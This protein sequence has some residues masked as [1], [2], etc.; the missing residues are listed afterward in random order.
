MVTFLLS[1][2]AE[3]NSTDEDGR[4]PFMLASLGG[5]LG[6]VRVLGEAMGGGRVNAE[7]EEGS[8]ALHLA[9]SEGHAE[10]VSFL[11]SMGAVIDTV[12]VDTRTPLMS[13]SV[14]GHV[15]V[16]RVL[17]EVMGKDE[18]EETDGDE[19]TALHLAADQ[20]HEEVV[21]VLL[22]KGAQTSCT[23]VE[24][25][26]PLMDGVSGGHLG[27]VKVFV[28]HRE[29]RGLEEVEDN[30]FTV[31]HLAAESGHVEVL[32]FLLVAGA[33]LTMTD[34]HGRTPRALAEAKGHDKCVAVIDVSNVRF[35]EV[36]I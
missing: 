31:L 13:A 32:R 3:A 9:A 19:I 21:R 36:S 27:V 6:V 8:T 12:D 7:D 24:G 35:F 15:G 29:G 20:G 34:H 1:E 2:G 18:L 26:T 33:D 28:Q 4:T 11:L 30:G 14:N 5:H 10:V 25:M 23:D 16:V 17:M 22:D